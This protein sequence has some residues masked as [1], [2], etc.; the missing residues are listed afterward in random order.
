MGERPQ[1]CSG[2]MGQTKSVVARNSDL[3]NTETLGSQ[4]SVP[5]L[6]GQA[7]EEVEVLQAS[8][9]IGTIAQ[10]VIAPSR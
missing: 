2:T 5:V 4:Q 10:I 6:V 9:K 3:Q 7:A 8:I 1:E